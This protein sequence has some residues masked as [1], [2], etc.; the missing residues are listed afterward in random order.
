MNFGIQTKIDNHSRQHLQEENQHLSH[1]TVLSP[2]G[3][4]VL[5]SKKG[6]PSK[7]ARQNVQGKPGM[8]DEQVPRIHG[9]RDSHI[10]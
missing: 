10:Q 8:T 4:Q 3:L 7:H 5:T 6:K 1:F 2:G 9:S